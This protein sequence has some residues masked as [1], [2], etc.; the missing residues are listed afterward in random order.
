MECFWS[1]SLLFTEYWL[2]VN[3]LFLN[4]WSVL[5]LFSEAFLLGGISESPFRFIKWNTLA[6]QRVRE[7]Q[8][9]AAAPAT[10]RTTAATIHPSATTTSTTKTRSTPT[11]TTTTAVGQIANSSFVNWSPSCHHFFVPKKIVCWV[12]SATSVTVVVGVVVVVSVVS[13]VD[14]DVAM[15]IQIFESNL[16]FATFLRKTVFWVIC[17]FP[18]YVDL[19]NW[20]P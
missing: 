18:A 2:C 11:T 16:S 7:R 19:D 14:V 6:G 8:N 4:G 1:L 15:S 17:Y 12:N 13:V 20:I 5:D 3:L 10:A 9:A